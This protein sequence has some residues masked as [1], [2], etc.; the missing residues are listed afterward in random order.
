MKLFTS[1]RFYVSDD[2]LLS[3]CAHTQGPCLSMSA[4]SYRDGVELTLELLPTQKQICW[5]ENALEKLRAMAVEEA[6]A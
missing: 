3:E 1:H 4:T 6:V 5:L 2:D